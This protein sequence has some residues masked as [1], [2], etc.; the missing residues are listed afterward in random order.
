MDVDRIRELLRSLPFRQAVWLFPLATALHFL[1]EAPH[2]ANW[3]GKYA[4][5]R[6]T[7]SRWVRIH[8]IGMVYV[9]A[10][11]TLVSLFRTA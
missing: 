2:F 7:R 6:Y 4:W 1:E 8:G 10:F 11:S 5:A 9:I 3:A